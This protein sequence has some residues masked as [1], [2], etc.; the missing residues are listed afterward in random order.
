M[1]YTSPERV[2][3]E[4]AA[5]QR[6]LT[7]AVQGGVVVRIVLDAGLPGQHQLGADVFTDYKGE[8]KEK[9]AAQPGEVFLLRPDA[10]IAFRA[11][12]LDLNAVTT[13]WRRWLSR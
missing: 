3:G 12:G 5:L 13:N 10:Y 1:V 8:F 2:G 9:L 4:G 11:D 6:L 7:L